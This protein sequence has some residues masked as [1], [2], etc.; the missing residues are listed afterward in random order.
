MNQMREAEANLKHRKRQQTKEAPKSEQRQQLFFSMM[1]TKY[2][3]VQKEEIRE[4]FE[5]RER[6][7]EALK[8]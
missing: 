4:G 7:E 5:K 3:N 2:S 8:E 6:G 1:T